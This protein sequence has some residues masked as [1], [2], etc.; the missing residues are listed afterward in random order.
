MRATRT[1]R[2]GRG[3]KPA[4]PASGSGMRAL[5]VV[6]AS[7]CAAI[8]TLGAATAQQA[9]LNP[10]RVAGYFDWHAG[11][12]RGDGDYRSPQRDAFPELLASGKSLA[13]VRAVTADGRTV[14]RVLPGFERMLEQPERRLFDNE[15]TIPPESEGAGGDLLGGGR[16]PAAIASFGGG[17]FRVSNYTFGSGRTCDTAQIDL[18]AAYEDTVAQRSPDLAAAVVPISC[19]DVIDVVAIGAGRERTYLL[20]DGAT[21]AISARRGPEIVELSKR[22]LRSWLGGNRR[23]LFASAHEVG[24]KVLIAVAVDDGQGSHVCVVSASRQGVM[25]GQLPASACPELPVF[26]SQPDRVVAEMSWRGDGQVLAVLQTDQRTRV[27]DLSIVQAGTVKAVSDSVLTPQ[28]NNVPYVA[29][30]TVAWMQNRLYWLEGEGRRSFVAFFDGKTSKRFGLP[31]ETP[32][33]GERCGLSSVWN[34]QAELACDAASATAAKASAVL[35]RQVTLDQAFAKD[36]NWFNRSPAWI[37][38]RCG[39]ETAS[40]IRVGH[41]VDVS[42][43]V[44]FQA[45]GSGREH[46]V[47]GVVAQIAADGV[48]DF[49][50][51]ARPRPD[52]KGVRTP[53]QGTDAL[54][55]LPPVQRIAV[56]QVP[57]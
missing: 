32:R 24:D 52:C 57:E 42:W 27:S 55:P 4:R 31:D 7:A 16:K 29:R 35:G 3:C 20:F 47:A 13:L 44:P 49:P 6:V 17:L 10:V 1:R 38:L 54:K 48:D 41:L 50:Y 33:S 12:G 46:V 51:T 14:L 18:Q 2:R 5:L 15:V 30:P 43:F 40:L 19:R 53:S 9:P 22:E 11:E 21:V 39:R 23:I 26:R 8:V 37:A 34:S 36:A 25:G 56:F 45:A 28:V